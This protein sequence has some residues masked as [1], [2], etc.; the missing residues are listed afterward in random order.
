MHLAPIS[1]R[2][3]GLI[4]LGMHRSGTSVLGGLINKMGLKTGGPLI[5]PGEDNSKGFFERIDVVLQN[6]YLMKLKRSITGLSHRSFR[7]GHWPIPCPG[8]IAWGRQNP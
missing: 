6:D 2:V 7:H 5:K 1:A 3:Q 8:G 4:V